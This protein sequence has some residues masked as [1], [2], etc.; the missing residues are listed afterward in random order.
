MK[1]IFLDFDGVLFDSVKEAYL[2]ARYSFYNIPIKEKIDAI[3][4]LK[5]KK[6]RY[7]ITHSWHYY[8]ILKL[9]D[10]GTDNDIF[11][12]EYYR[13][14]KN[15]ML[16]RDGLFDKKYQEQRKYL[17][18]R[19]YEFWKSLEAPYPFFYMINSIKNDYDIII[20]STKNEFAIKNHFDDYKFILSE[21]RIIGKEKLKEY[22]TKANFI[23]AYMK[24]RNVE[25]A[26]FIDDSEDNLR[27]CENIKNLKCIQAKW[28]YVTPN[29][30]SDNY[31]EIIKQIKEL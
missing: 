28:G 18:E 6:Y 15:R 3:H 31:E 8:Y 7:L 10:S 30:K 11:E 1:T 14:I 9:I 17:I 22:Q 16:V 23:K 2:L 29:I 24:L 4:Y 5:F 19:D 13:L 25:K 20:L 27:K 26:I 12:Q 21:E